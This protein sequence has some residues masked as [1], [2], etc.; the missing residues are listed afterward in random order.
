M[1]KRL[2]FIA[3][4]VTLLFSQAFAV[5]TEGYPDED[6]IFVT[7]FAIELINHGSKSHSRSS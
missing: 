4:T 5:F 2:S 1:K 7:A 6:P 3:A